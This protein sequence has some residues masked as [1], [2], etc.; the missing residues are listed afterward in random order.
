MR[1]KQWNQL[2]CKMEVNTS[3]HVSLLWWK[4]RTQS[5]HY[6]VVPASAVTTVRGWPQAVVLLNCVIQGYQTRFCFEDWNHQWVRA[7][8]NCHPVT[9]SAKLLQYS[10]PCVHFG[11]CWNSAV[12][13]LLSY[14]LWGKREQRSLRM[15]L[16]YGSKQVWWWVLCS[17]YLLQSQCPST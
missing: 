15:L 6:K 1:C 5:C 16:L 14:P 12:A 7:T 17:R 11:F 4:T 9:S 10:S 13:R 3:F 8:I 2:V